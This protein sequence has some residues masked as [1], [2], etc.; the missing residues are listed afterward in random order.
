MDQFQR[1]EIKAILC[2]YGAGGVGLNMQAGDYVVLHDRA[3]R[4]GDVEQIEGRAWRMGRKMPV[5]SVWPQANTT[6]AAVD[7]VLNAKQR[8]IDLIVDGKAGA[9]LAIDLVIDGEHTI[10]PDFKESI[11]EIARDLLDAIFKARHNI[12]SDIDTDDDDVD[13]DDGSDINAETGE[14]ANAN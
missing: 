3:W 12:A 2:T 13:D 5:I 1:G 9:S 8:N 11:G 7:Q 14:Y 4:P 10:L 6:D